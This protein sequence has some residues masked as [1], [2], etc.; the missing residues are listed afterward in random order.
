VVCHGRGLSSGLDPAI[1]YFYDRNILLDEDKTKITQTCVILVTLHAG[2]MPMV[3]FV[4]DMAVHT[5]W[6]SQHALFANVRC[7]VYAKIV[8]LQGAT[9]VMRSFVLIMA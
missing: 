5:A 4:Q 8:N 7:V 1:V 2:L 6:N 9:I 3:L